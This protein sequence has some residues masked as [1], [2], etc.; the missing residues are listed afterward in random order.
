MNKHE[1]NPHANFS[2]SYP[3]GHISQ[4]WLSNTFYFIRFANVV[5][6]SHVLLGTFLSVQNC[7]SQTSND[8]HLFSHS[9]DYKCAK[10][11]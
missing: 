7:S 1:F 8:D 11:N 5:Y 9:Y 10:Q 2:F 6:F 4:K 3:K